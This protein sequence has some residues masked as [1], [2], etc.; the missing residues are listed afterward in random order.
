MCEVVIREVDG[1]VEGCYDGVVRI[2]Y[3][4]RACTKYL[5]AFGDESDKFFCLNDALKEIGYDREKGGV[6]VVIIDDC[7]SGVVYE[8]GNYGD[9]KWYEYGKT[10]GYY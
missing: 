8:Y 9:G 2:V 6:V 4:N 5:T 10:R 3:G 7:T 1:K